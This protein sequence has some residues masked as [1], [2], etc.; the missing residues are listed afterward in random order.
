MNLALPTEVLKRHKILHSH[1]SYSRQITYAPIT[2]FEENKHSI[3]I[4]QYASV[5]RF[6]KPR[7]VELVVLHSVEDLMLKIFIRIKDVE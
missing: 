3:Q 4:K 6:S 1:C 2:Q 7:H 5:G